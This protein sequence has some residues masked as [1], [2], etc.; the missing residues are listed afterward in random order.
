MELTKGAAIINKHLESHS[1][2]IAERELATRYVLI[3]LAKSSCDSGDVTEER[4]LEICNDGIE[5]AKSLLQ[6]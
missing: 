4:L 3:V 6:K 1:D 2:D 5:F